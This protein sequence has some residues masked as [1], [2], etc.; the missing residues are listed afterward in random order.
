MQSSRGA[1]PAQLIK[2]R[3]PST[4]V[5]RPST[6]GSRSANGARLLAKVEAF[7]QGP[8]LRRGGRRLFGRGGKLEC[9]SRRW[10]QRSKTKKARSF[11]V[12]ALKSLIQALEDAERAE[13]DLKADQMRRLFKQFDES[14]D[15]WACA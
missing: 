14:R 11:A 1:D 7:R 2:L 6:T 10:Q 13:K 8:A 5:K 9:L 12:P 3:T 4:V 15:R